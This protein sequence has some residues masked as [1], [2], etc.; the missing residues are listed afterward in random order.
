MTEK[1]FPK[2]FNTKPQNIQPGIEKDMNPKPVFMSEEYD[3]DG[4][5]LKGKI[6]LITGG[7][8]GIGKATAI[9]Y[10]KEG[11]KV[12]IVYLN[13]DNDSEDTKSIIEENNG[14]CTLIK[15]DI[16]DESFCKE[17]VNKLASKYNKIDILICNAA[18][19]HYSQ[20]FED[21]TASQLEKTFR[22]NVYGTFF[23]IK[24][25]LNYM[26]EF[27]SIIITTSVT[28]YQ[29]NESLIDYSCTKGALSALTR[30]LALSLSKRNIRVNAVAPGPVWTPLIPSSMPSSVI[31]NFGSKTLLKRA[32]QPVELAEAYVF[33]ASKGASFVTGETIHVNGGEFLCN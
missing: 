16:G 9:A 25:A 29:G 8:S 6:A 22:T 23:I 10:A 5:R 17:A 2:V 1:S 18:E 28:A 15:G 30:S 19:Q 24:E 11:A 12:I 3:N 7:D 32:G 13:E 26:G 31:L 14:E 27:T 20:N 33:L 21:I 4:K